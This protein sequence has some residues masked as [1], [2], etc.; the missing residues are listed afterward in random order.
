MKT[1]KIEELTTLAQ[2]MEICIR[3]LNGINET[4]K[5]RV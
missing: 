2:E 1:I 4:K 5:Y 3:G